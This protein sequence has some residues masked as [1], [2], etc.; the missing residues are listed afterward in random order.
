MSPQELKDVIINKIL[1]VEGGYVNHPS[2]KGGATNYGITEAVA[3]SNGFTGD[4]R[5]LPRELAYSIYEKQY[6]SVNK[7]TE[8]ASLSAGIAEE[9]AD[10]GVNMG[11]KTAATFLQ[12]TLNALNMKGDLF[13][14]LVVDGLIGT[15]SLTALSLVL[16]K[17]KGSELA[18]LR[19]LNSL[20]GARYIELTETREANKD[21]VLGWFLN[22]VTM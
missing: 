19:M 11:V 18:I 22:R 4:M 16:N 2:D 3:R 8:I 21:F 15:K 10:T 7:L 13:P 9:L 6:W 14:N 1:I 20:Q 12:R 5:D 17:R